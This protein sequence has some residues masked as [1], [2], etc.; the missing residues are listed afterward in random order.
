MLKVIRQVL[1]ALSGWFFLESAFEMYILTPLHGPQMLFF[2]LAHIAPLLLLPIL[3]VSGLA[4]ICLMV[5][6]AALQVGR[7]NSGLGE[8]QR[9]RNVMLI[10]LCVQAVHIGLLLTYDH[11]AI[12]LFAMRSI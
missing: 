6:A 5:F 9:V 4:F 2:S 12:A 11:W 1:V 10:I 7:F 3:F 8:G